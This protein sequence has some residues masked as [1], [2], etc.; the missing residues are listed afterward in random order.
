MNKLLTVALVLALTSCA[1][2]QIGD[3]TKALFQILE[4]QIIYCSSESDIE[5]EKILEIIRIAKP[6]YTG[7]C[8]ARDM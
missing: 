5:R 4:L 8:E 3:G 2:Y 7:I 1:N 6:E